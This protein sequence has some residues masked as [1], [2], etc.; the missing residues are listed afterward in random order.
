MGKKK[1]FSPFISSSFHFCSYLFL[2]T[3]SLYRLFLGMPA[4]AH[5]AAPAGDGQACHSLGLPPEVSRLPP[6]AHSNCHPRKRSGWPPGRCQ[7]LGHLYRTALE[8]PVICFWCSEKRAFGVA[9]ETRREKGETST[10]LTPNFP[11]TDDISDGHTIPDA[12]ISLK[13]QSIYVHMLCW[14]ED[15]LRWPKPKR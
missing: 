3:S 4:T 6:G 10:G 9:A 14:Q 13:I 11:W 5:T 12:S 7:A 15:C 2:Q 1:P 8:S